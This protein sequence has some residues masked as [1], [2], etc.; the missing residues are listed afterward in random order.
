[1]PGSC[2]PGRRARTRACGVLGLLLAAWIAPV[3]GV[4]EESPAPAAANIEGSTLVLEGMTYVVSDGTKNEMVVAAET[5]RVV[6][7][8]DEAHLDDVHARLGS[9]APGGVPGGG[10]EMR[11]D[12]GVFHLGTRDFVATG[13][14]RGLT[15]D[16][17]RFRTE[18]LHYRASDGFVWSDE[19]VILRDKGALLEGTG[20]EYYVR[21]D[22]FRLRKARIREEAS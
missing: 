10:M 9:R 8:R 16:G 11:C 7:D 14:V 20:F 15:S 12:G 22:R 17:R 3:A 1:M 21:E 18:V 5:A 6:P 4:A 13:N 19:A 2:G